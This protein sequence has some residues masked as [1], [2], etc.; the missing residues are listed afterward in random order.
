MEAWLNV[1]SPFIRV[2]KIMKTT[3]LSGEWIDYDHVFTYIEQG[4]ADF[5]LNGVKYHVSEG[6]AIL[7]PPFTPHIIRTT[8][9]VPMI[10]YIFHFDLFYDEERSEWKEINVTKEKHKKVYENEMKL[11]S[12]QPISRLRPADQIDLKK[13]FLLM[14]K[15]SQDKQDGY[16]LHS[17]SICIE[18]LYMFLKSQSNAK[19]PEGRLTK[20]WVLIEK[21]IDFI[22]EKFADPQLNNVAISDH[23]GISTNHLSFLF[24][25]QLD[26]SIHKYV[27]HVRI[28]QAK[29]MIVE[30]KKTLTVIAEE[31]GFSSI[32]LFS[33]SFKATVGLTPSQFQATYSQPR[34]EG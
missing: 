14:H 3:S 21:S 9:A 20:G 23:V 13:R 1:I 12:I 10:Q 11:A 34:R 15:V 7:M 19:H 18:L 30:G 27:T 24:K 2:V 28:E 16:F 8:S 5:W 31:V 22:N 32:H 6:D 17:K 4:D 33:R 25:E 29:Q 26:V